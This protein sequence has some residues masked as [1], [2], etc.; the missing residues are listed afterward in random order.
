[1]TDA[2]AGDK[3]PFLL[4][5]S[6]HE[7]RSPLS[8]VSGYISF[9]LKDPAGTFDARQRQ[10]LELAQKSCTRL[11]RVMVEM[12]ELSKLEAGETKLRRAPLDLNLLLAEVVAAVADTLPEPDRMVEVVLTT[13]PVSARILGDAPNL[14][15]ALTSLLLSIRREVTTS[16][17]LFVRARVGIF[18]GRPASWIAMADIDQ[19]ERLDA[20]RP[21]SLATFDEWRGGCGLTLP[22]ARRIIDGHDGAI[23]SPAWPPDEERKPGMR[24]VGAVVVLPHA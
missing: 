24:K 14:K 20:A 4:N 8:V 10:W 23:W 11:S 21:E 1:M 6:V 7:L 19:I 2:S 12:T 5:L 22:F 16:G 13:E 18:K 9:L 3:D 15:T 17:R